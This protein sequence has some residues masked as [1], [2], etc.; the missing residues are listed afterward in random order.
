MSVEGRRRL[1]ERC[2]TRPIA[3]VAAEMG[4]SRQCASKW[5]NRHDKYGDAGLLDRPSV[6]H[7]QPTAT[8]A[9]VVVRIEKMRRDHKWSARRIAREL[10][11]ESVTV[12]VRTVSRHLAYLGLNRRRFIDPTGE[13][14]REPR[15]IH[16]RWPGHMV[17]LDVKKVGVISD[18]GG[19]RVH[20]RGSEQAKQSMRGRRRGGRARYTYLHTA[21]DGFSR[22]AYTE[23]LPDEQARTAIGFTHRARAFF[24]AHGIAHVHRI[25]T[26]NGSCYRARDFATVL[27][28]A[29]HQRITPYTPRHNGKVERYHRILAEEFLYAHTWTSE[30]HRSE[31]LKVWN[32]HYNY[33]RPHTTAGNQP[34]VTRLHT[35]VTNV[36]TSYS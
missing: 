15:R 32:I 7:H 16:A 17:H 19:W 1:I 9:Q 6:P 20:G 5:V 23:A 27:R 28:G 31:A 2:R 21:I 34:P 10:A 35:G 24:T 11:G 8:P 4:I 14:N 13:N 25:V 26:D 22:L 18:G 12:A 29:R 3:H 33:H 30:Q 36:V